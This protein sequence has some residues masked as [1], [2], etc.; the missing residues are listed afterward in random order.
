MNADLLDRRLS[1]NIGVNDLFDWNRWSVAS[2]NPYLMSNTDSKPTSRYVSL[3][4]TLRFGKTD[5]KGP[6]RRGGR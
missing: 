2:A 4:A 1:L 3:S 6:E 5:L